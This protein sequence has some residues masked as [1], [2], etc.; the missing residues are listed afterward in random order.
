MIIQIFSKDRPLQLEATLH[1]LIIHCTD[2]FDHDIFIIY[3][4]SSNDYKNNYDILLKEY[5]SYKN[6]NFILENDFKN[7]VISL[8]LSYE[9]ILWLVDDNIFVRDFNLKELCEELKINRDALG[10]SLRLGKNTN[11]CYPLNKSQ[12]LPKFINENS[13]I[14][15]YLWTIAEYDFAYPLEVSSSIYK[16]GDILPLL[17][18]INFNNPN[19]LESELERNVDYFR[20]YYP[21]LLCPQLSY[22][23]CNPINKVQNVF[24]SNRSSNL[25][26]YSPEK[27]AELFAEGYKI[28]VEHYSGYIPN[29]CHQE[30]ELLFNQDEDKGKKPVV[31]VIIP[32]YN[33]AEYLRDAV[34]SVVNQTYKDWECIIVNDGSPDNTSK[35]ANQL[36]KEYKQFNIKLLEKVN[37]GLSDA[38]NAGIAISGGKYILPLDSDDKISPSYLEETVSILDKNPDYHIVYVDEQNFGVTNHIHRKGVSE[39]QYLMQYNVHDYCSLYRKELWISAGGYSV[40][41]F[42]GGEDWNF[43]IAAAKSGFKSYHLEKPL[44]MY[45]SRVGTMVETTLAKIDEVKAH[46]IIQHKDIFR[47]QEI[48]KAYEIIRNMPESSSQGL[49]KVLQKHPNNPL[50]NEL[51]LIWKPEE[52]GTVKV[53]VIIPTFN[54]PDLLKIAILSVIQQ[55]YNDYEIIVVNDCGKSVQLVIDEFDNKKIKYIEHTTNKGLAASRNTGIKCSKGKYLCY[56][57]DDDFFYP[58]HLET[59]VRFLE[60]SNFKVAYTDAF[61]ASQHLQNG[62]YVTTEKKVIYSEEFNYPKLLVGNY[63]PILCVMHHRDCLLKS[64]LYDESLSTHEDWE[65]WLRIGLNYEFAHIKKATCEFTWRTDGSSMT[66]SRR[67]DMLRTLRIIYNKTKDIVAGNEEILH[68]RNINEKSIEIEV[69]KIQ[70]KETGGKYAASTL[71]EKP[72]V[73]IIIPVHNNLDYTRKCLDGIRKTKGL[74]KIEIIIINNGSS[75]GTQEFLRSLGNEIKVISNINNEN[76]AYVNNQGA[77][78]ASGKYLVFLNNDTFPFPGWLDAFAKEFHDNP[79]VGIQ[80]AKLLY[81]NGTIQHAGMIFGSRPGRPEEPYHAYLTADPS[82]PLVNRRREMQFV[83]GACLAIRSELF[84]QVGGFDDEYIFGWEDTDLCMKVNTSGKKI[85]YNPEAV[86]YHYESGTKKLR[87]A[88]GEDMLELDT[89]KEIRNRERFMSRWPQF[90]KRDAELFYAEDGLKMQGNTLVPISEEKFKAMMES[91]LKGSKPKEV[92]K[93]YFTGFSKK[94]LD[95]NYKNAKTVLVKSPPAIGDAFA[96]TALTAELKEKYPQLKIYI[97]GNEVVGDVFL[98]HN[99]IE[100]IILSGSEEE[101]AIESMADVVVDYTNIIAKLPEYYNG[102]SYMDIFGNIAGIRFTKQDIIYTITEK[103]AEWAK[104]EISDFKDGKILI[105]IQLF[106]NKDQK[107]SYPFVKDL[108]KELQSRNPDFRFILLGKESPGLNL[109]EIYDCAWKNIPFR[110]QMALAQHCGKFLT[111]DSAFYHA[112][113]NYFKKPTM[114]LFGLTNP[115]LSG[116]PSAGFAVVRNN[117]LNCLNCYW[118]IPCNIECMH[119]LQPSVIADEFM[120]IENKIIK[121]FDLK[122]VLMNISPNTDVDEQLFGFYIN[123][124]DTVRLKLIDEKNILPAYFENANGIEIVREIEKT[125]VNINENL[126]GFNFELEEEEETKIVENENVETYE[127]AETHGNESPQENNGYPQ[128]NIVWEGSQFVYHSLALINREQCANIIDTGLAEVTIVP[129]ENDRFFPGGNPKYEKLKENDIRYKKEVNKDNARLPYVWIRHQWPPSFDAP[130]GAKWIIMQPWEYT[131]LRKDF[132]DLFKQA[133]ELWTPST[134]SRQSFINSGID[135]DKVQVIPNGIDP[136]LFNPAG[137]KY[138]IP[139]KK[140]LKFLYIGGTIFR[141][142]ID[143]LLHAYTKAFNSEDN[144]SLF[145]KDMGGESFY[146]GQTAKGHIEK[147]RQVPGS[148]EI[149]YYD[150]YMTEEQIANLYR[151]CDVFVCSYRGEGFSLPTLEAMACGLPVIVTE[152]GST[153]DFVDEKVGWLIPSQPRTIGNKIGNLELTG[154]AFVLEP[155]AEKLIEILKDVY[156]NPAMIFDKGLKGSYRA[157]TQW[158]WKRSTMKIF[159]RLDFLYGKNMAQTAENKLKDCRDA[160]VILGEADEQFDLGNY[161]LAKQLYNQALEDGLKPEKFKLH[162]LHKLSMI[163]IIE[164]NYEQAEENLA[165]AEAMSA[166]HPDNIYLKAKLFGLKKNWTEMLEQLTELMNKWKDVKFNTTLNVALDDLLCDTA[167]GFYEFGDIENSLNLYTEALKLNNGNPYACYGAALCFLK[168]DIKEDAI[169]MLEWA[170]RLKPDYDLAGDLLST[171]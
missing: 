66:S 106:T 55:T 139:T 159:S 81:E 38:R 25:N 30:V 86:L 5:E 92:K 35:I 63:I 160:F 91:Q 19:T 114:V 122:T 34:E 28:K 153:D 27:L 126:S 2:L 169:K 145:I 75:D 67:A 12:K 118:R 70:V 158:T 36:I 65:L 59:L 40:L 141:K 167:E 76:Y 87:Q 32:C 128:L 8:I 80:G 133:D 69:N 20:E 71:P 33:Q 132:A 73:S 130:R 152:G 64:G 102:I 29:A 39:L 121:K 46:I 31:S 154:E 45:R 79:D 49:M 78:I 82:L 148:P 89:P 112:G 131:T 156:S 123:N 135:F 7:N 21:Y 10:L 58:G 9:Y 15:K 13:A 107:R 44:F 140:K 100:D 48:Q 53:S 43:W 109:P 16:V 157:R 97:S 1:S 68:H 111:I 138:L 164:G 26:A 41:M 136:G 93:E 101:L 74:F 103:E 150:D 146:K 115:A 51:Y 125:P 52:I 96:L 124:K 6:I 90:I 84:R 23:F 50:L 143:V 17:L 161:Y 98:N 22:T 129:Y 108:V 3:K 144:V 4:T 166:G 162:L 104:N 117:E 110:L 18:K 42:I 37:G 83:T 11:Y 60:N 77:E 57:D 99:D 88:N 171:L 105:G 72:E 149:I 142:G 170:I 134:Y 95:R 116:N 54:R 120:Q 61:R 24:L 147:L 62:E 94:F 119:K 165:V 14:L 168:A 85:I 127:F 151:S 113:H 47:E 56:L 163:E 155:D 137:D